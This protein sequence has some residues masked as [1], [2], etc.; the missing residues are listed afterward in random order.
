MQHRATLH[1]WPLGR[2]CGFLLSCYNGYNI[3]TI[4]RIHKS[5]GERSFLQYAGKSGEYVQ[6]RAVVRRANDEDNPHGRISSEID[7][8]PGYRH[9]D[10]RSRKHSPCRTPWM[11]NGH[12][13]DN[14][15]IHHAFAFYEKRQ[16][17]P[18]VGHHTG[19]DKHGDYLSEGRV[20]LLSLQFGDY[21]IWTHKSAEAK[22]SRFSDVPGSLRSHGRLLSQMGL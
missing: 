10:H 15:R 12:A 4:A 7:A 13:G 2:R 18:A 19:P 8:L 21:E 6:V 22:I 5:F 9:C 14:D 16:K 17:A 20:M 1:L 11:R 3:V